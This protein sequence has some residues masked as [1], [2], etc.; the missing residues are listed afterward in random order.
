[1]RTIISIVIIVC[2]SVAYVSC[3]GPP[4]SELDDDQWDDLAHKI[5]DALKQ[6]ASEQGQKFIL[7][8]IKSAHKVVDDGVKY[9]VAAEFEESAGEKI[10]CSLSLLVQQEQFTINC[11]EKEYKVTTKT[12]AE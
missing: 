10:T 4:L 2:C 6:L 3:D 11:N 8:K 12:E 1:M 5:D 7:I 9:L